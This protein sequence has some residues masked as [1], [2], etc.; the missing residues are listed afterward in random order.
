MLDT[1]QIIQ[2]SYNRCLADDRFFD[3][4]YDIFLK[5]SDEIAPKF[6]NTDFKKQKLLIKA[7]V[8]ML[9]KFST[10]NEHVLAAVEKLGETHSRQGH[11]IRPELYELWLDSL[12]E[13]LEAHDPEFS[14]ELEARWREEMRNGIELI[15]SRY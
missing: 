1:A 8:G 15:I 5:K 14:S 11:D 6:A 7:S 10:G 13:T 9:V 2:D 3:T 12:C 4:F